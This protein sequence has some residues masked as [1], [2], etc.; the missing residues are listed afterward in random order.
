MHTIGVTT[1]VTEVVPG[2]LQGTENAP[3]SSAQAHLHP[4]VVSLRSGQ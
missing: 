2:V 4:L 3:V 1:A